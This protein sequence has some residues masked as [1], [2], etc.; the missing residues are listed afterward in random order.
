MV[1]S[2][3]LHQSQTYNP[4]YNVVTEIIGLKTEI[5]SRKLLLQ[6]LSK[7]IIELLD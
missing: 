1:K 5:K 7:K 6:N 4:E 3:P 2:N